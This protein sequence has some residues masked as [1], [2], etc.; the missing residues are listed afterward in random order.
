MHA[1]HDLSGCNKAMEQTH[2]SLD[3]EVAWREQ[4][5]EAVRRIETAQGELSEATAALVALD[6]A[7][8]TLRAARAPVQPWLLTLPE[9]SEAL[10]IGMTKLHGLIRSGALPSVQIG[11]ARRVRVEAVDAYVESLGVEQAS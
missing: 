7:G 3:P 6:E 8:T 1:T 10:P 2:R 5:F 9:A 11:T 4:R